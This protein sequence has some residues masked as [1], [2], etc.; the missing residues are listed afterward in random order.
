M[1]SI[2]VISKD[3]SG[4]SELNKLYSNQG[5]LIIKQEI[6]KLGISKS[7]VMNFFKS[8][9]IKHEK[10]AGT[11]IQNFQYDPICNTNKYYLFPRFLLD[12]VKLFFD[13]FG[14]STNVLD[15]EYPA[16]LGDS[17]LEMKTLIWNE[18]NHLLNNIIIP[19]I[20]KSGGLTLQLDT[21]KGKTVI[22]SRIIQEF[23]LKTVIF[24]GNILLQKQ[25][26][27]DVTEHLGL[28]SDK[29]RLVGGGNK[30]HPDANIWIVTINT[31]SKLNKDPTIWNQF[32]L[33]IFDECHKFCSAKRIFIARQCCTKYKL[34]LS[35]TVEKNWNWKEIIYNCGSPV[36]G[37]DYIKSESIDGNVKIIK[38]Y[39]PPEYT[40]SLKSNSGMVSTAFMSRQFMKDSYRTSILISETIRLL[41]SGH[42]VL[43]LTN[44][45]DFVWNFYELFQVKTN[46]KYRVGIIN[47]DV[48]DKEKHYA[49]SSC[50]LI[51]STYGSCSEGVNIPRLTAMVFLTSFVGNGIQISGRS[52]R[53]KSDITREY[54][55]LIDMNTSLKKQFASR[56]E[57]WNNRKFTQ[58]IAIEKYRNEN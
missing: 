49:K 16:N 46:W 25:L 33:S 22:L 7:D 18:K 53:G 30:N 31:A 36:N 14:I 4:I 34:A 27:Q 58:E 24:A 42:S 35:A 55:D 48:S 29:I 2:K 10:R 3:I 12:D 5:Y 9:H 52:L 15:F 32:G 57:I 38:Y 44:I 8:F 26:Y 39:G 17:N 54:I 20:K 45:N 6:G 40:K 56:G 21:G 19:K 43:A 50:Q 47:S 13:E 11:I 51:L 1:K 37:N 28:T 41:E 23:G